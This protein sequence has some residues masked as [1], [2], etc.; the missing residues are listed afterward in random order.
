MKRRESIG[1]HYS[2]TD[3]FA[4]KLICGDCGGFYGRK[5]WHS[6][7]KYSRFIYQCNRK[8]EKGKNKCQ[9]PNLTEEQ[10]KLKFIE[11]YNLTMK[12]KQQILDDTNDDIKVLT[13]TVQLDREIESSNYEL[14][15]LT[16]LINRSI[17]ENSKTLMNNDDFNNKYT[18]LTTRYEQ[19]KKNLENRI[20]TRKYKNDHAIK[21]NLFR[22]SI[23]KFESKLSDWNEQLWM[24]LVENAT[25]YN[26]KSLHFK[27]SD[28]KLI[29]KVIQKKL[30]CKD[31]NVIM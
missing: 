2:S 14:S 13:D 22:D 12:D 27:V 6:N 19:T 7:S 26:D 11:A 31:E 5:E 30:D 8:F 23:S 24:V 15:V 9:T 16:E 10:I 28:L 4:S 29:N 3:I 25:I 1:A 20:G 18:E 17:K 21:M